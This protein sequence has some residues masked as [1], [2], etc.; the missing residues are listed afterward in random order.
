MIELLGIGFPRQ[1][2][3]WLFRKVSARLERGQLTFLVSPD[4]EARLAV[5]DAVAARR[6]P[7]EGRAWVG[8]IPVS[9]ETAR[10]VQARVGEVDLSGPLNDRGSLVGNVLAAGGQTPGALKAAIRLAS[11]RSRSLAV[12]ALRR[13]GLDGRAHERVATLD[14]WCRRRLLVARAIVGPPDYLIVREVDDGLSLP[15][16]G[17]ILGVLRRVARSDRLTVL[18]T[19]EHRALVYLYADRVLILAAGALEFDGAPERLTEDRAGP[20][21]VSRKAVPA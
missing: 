15:E 20:S 4:R 18:A 3:E 1:G 6:I 7:T 17:D 12:D 2:D 13:V 19:V 11:S 21:R 16:A 5:L 8:G 10:R 14:P 9:S